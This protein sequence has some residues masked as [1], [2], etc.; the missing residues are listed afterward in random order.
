MDKELVVADCFGNGD[1]TWNFKRLA[2][3]VEAGDRIQAR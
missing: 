2:S 3:T 1:K